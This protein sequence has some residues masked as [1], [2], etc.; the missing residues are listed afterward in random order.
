M[1]IGYST[2]MEHAV[3][4]YHLIYVWF[5]FAFVLVCLF[6]ISEEIRQN[7]LKKRK[8]IAPNNSEKEGKVES[9]L[10]DN[11]KVTVSMF[12]VVIGLMALTH[13]QANR[14]QIVIPEQN[15]KISLQA[16]GLGGLQEEK[17]SHRL[18]WAPRYVGNSA[19]KLSHINHNG[20]ELDL[21]I[22]YFDGSDGE[23]VSSLHRLYE[24]D[25]W[26][27]VKRTKI[28]VIQQP[29]LY[30]LVT[31]SI[32]V[33]KQILYWYVINGNIV[34]SYRDVKIFQLLQTLK[35]YPTESYVI[36]VAI[37]I[38][39]NEQNL[40][41]ELL[42]LSKIIINSLDKQLMIPVTD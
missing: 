10:P 6:L 21:Y 40:S 33:K 16:L 25:R 26:T 17:H 2:N 34:S 13:V 5:F 41:S 30:D 18:I 36:A 1:Y 7:E 14:M 11:L 42:S 37:D 8:A 20:N 32:G 27:L 19:E 39:Q 38:E 3:G 29:V 9:K 15:T 4:A 31:S 35:G 24:Q 23:L 12:I 22:A 28:D